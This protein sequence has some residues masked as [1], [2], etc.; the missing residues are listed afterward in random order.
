MRKRN[1]SAAHA[2]AY[3]VTAFPSW[4][5]LAEANVSVDRVMTVEGNPSLWH[6][7]AVHAP[8]LVALTT[9]AGRRALRFIVGLRPPYEL[10]FSLWS[11][12][13]QI[14]REGRTLPAAMGEVR[15]EV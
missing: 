11:F 3:G 7:A 15:A 10:A 8:Q 9:A 13:S 5:A 12:L 14:G 4:R 2:R 1:F 6:S